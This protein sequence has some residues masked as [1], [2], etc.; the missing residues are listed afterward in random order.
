MEHY[1][2][3]A[4]EAVLYKGAVTCK[5]AGNNIEFILTNLFLV[6]VIKTKKIFSK[7]EI[8]VEKYSV[9]DIKFYNDEPQIKQQGANVEI[10]LLNGEETVTFLSKNEANKFVSA[11]LE[12][13]TGKT[14]LQRTADKAKSTVDAVDNTFGIDTVGTVK[15]ILE[16]GSNIAGI[17]GGKKG[18]TIQTIMG[19]SN[20]VARKEEVSTDMQIEQ[21]RK[22]KQLLDEGII[23][24]EEFDL[25]RKEIMGL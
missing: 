13:L 7:E 24:Q 10:Y 23:T 25:K 22:L 15:N 16:I 3:Q 5:G 4:D 20:A 19:V 8:K 14:K 2:L 11:L 9:D 18:K 12:L 6:F 1:S 21:L 17:F